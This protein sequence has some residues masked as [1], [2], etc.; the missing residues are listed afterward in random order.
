[1]RY[2]AYH[3]KCKTRAMELSNQNKIKI[4]FLMYDLPFWKNE[5]LFVALKHHHR[6]TP[7]FWITSVP[8]AHDSEIQEEAMRKCLN[9]AKEHNF[10]YLVDIDFSEL[11]KL[12]NPDYIF[13]VHPYDD[14]IPF[15]ISELEK[16]LPCFIP[17]GYSNM[18]SPRVYNNYKLQFFYRFYLESSYIQKEAKKYMLNQ[19]C[20]TKVS[21]LPMAELLLSNIKNQH[22]LVTKNRSFKKYIIWAPHWSIGFRTAGNFDVSTFNEIADSMIEIANKYK[23]YLYF[24]FKPHPLLKSTLYQEPTWGK[25]RTDAYW[26]KWKNKPHMRTEEGDYI[27][28]FRQSEALIHDCGSFI[29]EYLLID[30]PCMYLQRKGAHVRFNESTKLALECYQ[31]GSDIQDI[32]SFINGV[33]KGEDPLSNRRRQFI[34]TYL[35][36]SGQSPVQ[37]I[38]NDLLNP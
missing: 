21:G 11:K 19:A 24:V 28:L 31:K 6:F 36:P 32:E 2:P 23:D 17:Y 20:N 9:Y 33:L 34:N 12:F 5:A 38:I 25:I 10:D 8:F 35:L 14:H 16:V 4:A 15:E 3:A 7:I 30:K 13:V 26:N 18:S 27:D 29:Q 37:N 22:S 1:M